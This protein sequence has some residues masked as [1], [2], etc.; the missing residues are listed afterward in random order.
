MSSSE[1]GKAAK[2]KAE[3]GNKAPAGAP[4]GPRGAQRS[5]PPQ[6]KGAQI[7]QP[8]REGRVVQPMLGLRQGRPRFSVEAKPAGSRKHLFILFTQ[9]ARAVQQTVFRDVVRLT[10]WNSKGDDK[11]PGNQLFFLAEPKLRN[12]MKEFDIFRELLRAHK[13]LIGWVRRMGGSITGMKEVTLM[14]YCVSQ[15]QS[16]DLSYAKEED[17]LEQMRA[18]EK[19]E[20][21][22]ADAKSAKMEQD[23]Q[24][25]PERALEAIKKEE[26]KVVEKVADPNDVSA[27]LTPMKVDRGAEDSSEEESFV[28]H[29]VHEET[30]VPDSTGKMVPVAELLR[31]AELRGAKN[32]MVRF[33]PR[34]LCSHNANHLQREAKRKQAAE[35][36]EQS[37]DVW[38]MLPKVEAFEDSNQRKRLKISPTSKDEEEDKGP[39]V[40]D[41]AASGFV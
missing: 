12:D 41:A 23:I 35:A 29:K 30:L 19:E 39:A 8:P 2:N 40:S 15:M 1:K 17:V 20:K 24:A 28:I 37:H 25:A 36:V 22:A 27:T 31:R 11:G 16:G 38:D 10:W 14:D 9:D 7:I 34:L 5:G 6:Q 21:K 32:A 26:E 13:A 3:L 4:T 18:F 33:L